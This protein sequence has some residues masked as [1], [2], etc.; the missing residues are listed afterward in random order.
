M[1]AIAKS[2]AFIWAGR[3]TK[4]IG[5]FLFLWLFFL[6]S[7]RNV[8]PTLTHYVFQDWQQIQHI[9]LALL[10]L[11]TGTSDT[12]IGYILRA[13]LEVKDKAMA[14]A[15][16]MWQIMLLHA[17]SCANLVCVGLVFLF[18]P[19]D[20]PKA[21]AL[22][23]V[24]GHGLMFGAVATAVS[25]AVETHSNLDDNVLRY[26]C[27]MFLPTIS[28]IQVMML[29]AFFPHH[30]EAVHMG[31]AIDCQ[32]G[33]LVAFIYG[34]CIGAIVTIALVEVI[35]RGYCTRQAPSTHAS[36]TIEYALVPMT[37]TV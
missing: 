33:W 1:H 36:Q 35:G 22:H 9:C 27:L 32:P 3:A 37:N 8:G 14:R 23:Q 10:L 13:E 24:L 11:A 5:G 19:Q 18:H 2:E 16:M 7:P 29:L 12:T 21:A 17:M 30:H 31:Y 28:W 26:P 6:M 4:F 15:R 34:C 20:D 25:K